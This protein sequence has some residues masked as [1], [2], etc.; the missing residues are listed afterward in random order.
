MAERHSGSDGIDALAMNLSEDLAHGSHDL[1]RGPIR[2]P[3]AAGGDENVAPAR[4]QTSEPGLNL[5]H[6][7]SLVRCR[8]A[9]ELRSVRRFLKP[10][11]REHDERAI[12]ESPEASACASLSGVLASL[13]SLTS[14]QHAR[15]THMKR[16]ASSPE[17]ARVSSPE[18]A[19]VSSPEPARVQCA[20]TGLRQFPGTV[21]RQFPGPSL[22]PETRRP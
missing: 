14:N 20:G 4:R 9:L 15:V 3:V 7:D 22:D 12:A 2:Q 19:R 11:S 13:A 8:F 5:L 10:T 1:S 18:P 6:P 17:P 21:T 16:P